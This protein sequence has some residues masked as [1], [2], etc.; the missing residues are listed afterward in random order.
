MRVVVTGAGGL[1]GTAVAKRLSAT[2]LTHADLD[3]TDAVATRRAMTKLRPELIVNCAVIGVD[4]CEANPSVAQDVNVHGPAT[5]AEWAE[6]S[7]AA[8]LHFSTN[9]V[10]D[11]REKHVYGPEDPPN[12]IN[13]YG[14]TK[15][16][17]E[18]AVF[19]RCSRVFV[20]RSSWIFGPGK[21]A[22]VSTVHKRLRAGERV[23]AVSDV[24]ASATYV[25]DLVARVAQIVNRHEYGLH[26]VV[27]DGVCSN[28]SF[29]REAA[30]LAGADESLVI[31]TVSRDVQK[32]RR[33]K[34]TPLRGNAPLRDWRDALAA[35]I[36]STS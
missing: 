17:G 6:K 18:C 26:H 22:F 2:A 36:Q 3:I 9:Y 31:P 4:E 21:E 10:F 14:R 28:E 16:T 33:P 12:P 8:I 27:N 29:A 24:F 30:R 35:Y 20:V 23:R 1:V 19:F 7:G 34:Y 25:D 32:A 13:T 15:L 11:G 5:L